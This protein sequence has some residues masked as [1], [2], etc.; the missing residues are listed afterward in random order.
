MSTSE[1]MGKILMIFLQFRDQLKIYHFQTKSYA[2]HKASDELAGVISEQMD[3]FMETLQGS[4]D[5]RLSITQEHVQLDNLSDEQMLTMLKYFKEW[6][7]NGI[8]PYLQ[9]SD[10]DL[11]NIR[12]EILGSVN[13]TLYLF[14]LL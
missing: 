6:L 9:P 10:K 7:I 12:D 14:S 5:N 1:Q 13:K 8:Q 2:R 11:A 3:L 4:R